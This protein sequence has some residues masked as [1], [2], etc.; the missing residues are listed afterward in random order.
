MLVP[1][2]VVGLGSSLRGAVR[3]RWSQISEDVA[4][5]L[6]SVATLGLALI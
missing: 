3:R 5:E 4:P 2:F 1:H 6:S